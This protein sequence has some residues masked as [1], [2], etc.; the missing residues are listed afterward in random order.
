MSGTFAKLTIER[1]DV[2]K[3]GPPT[4]MGGDAN[5]FQA[6][7]NPPDLK[8]ELQIQY[9]RDEDQPIGGSTEDKKLS[10]YK[11]EAV[12]FTLI[13]DSTGAVVPSGLPSTDPVPVADQIKKLVS[14][15][16]TL[17][18][19]IHEPNV[20]KISWG[21]NFDKFFAR[22]NKLGF[23]YTLFK[24]NGEPLRAKVDV[25]FLR[26][27]TSKQAELEAAKSS[28]DLTHTVLVVEGDTLPLLCQRIYRDPSRYIEVAEY[29]DLTDFR[30]LKPNTV[31][32]FPPIV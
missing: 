32:H 17:K 24:S 19:D 21:S 11:P 13:L 6:M 23:N 16:Y 18:G 12:N 4:P 25:A 10:R 9:N 27:K 1:C 20:V 7:I 2:P 31:L 22:S 14:I 28:P 15:C 5:T 29:N 30:S 3:S 8:R 26:F